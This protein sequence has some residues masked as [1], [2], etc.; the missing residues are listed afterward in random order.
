MIEEWKKIDGF[1]GKYEISNHGRVRSS[2]YL[3]PRILKGDFTRGYNS[4]FFPGKRIFVH[5]LVA[6]YFVENPNNYQQVNHIDENKFNNIASNLEWIT[7]RENIRYSLTKKS[8]TKIPGVHFNARMGGYQCK[9]YF[10]KKGRYLGF[11]KDLDKAIS[12]VSEFEK[13]SNINQ[14]NK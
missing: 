11:T 14:I 8:K 12:L 5:R 9:V 6:I 3:I 2:A 1:K 7:H 4:V 13:L 10:N